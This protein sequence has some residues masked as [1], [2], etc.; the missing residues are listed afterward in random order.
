[1]ILGRNP[2]L[3]LGLATAVL[4]AAVV[5]FGVAL[6][7]IQVETIMAVVSA[8]IGIVANEA[9]PTTAGTLAFTTKAPQ[10]TATT[11]SGTASSTTP[12]P[13]SGSTD[14]PGA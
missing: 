12:T 4:A 11:P 10:L 2:A 5:V 1:M 3:W 9:D 8:I 14:E 6:S 13:A 7:T